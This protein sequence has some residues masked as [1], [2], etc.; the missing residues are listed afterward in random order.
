MFQFL[1]V[2]APIYS[3][4]PHDGSPFRLQMTGDSETQEREKKEVMK[5]AVR[6]LLEAFYPTSDPTK[7]PEKRV[8]SEWRAD[9]KRGFFLGIIQDGDDE[10][11]NRLH[12]LLDEEHFH[13][14]Q[15]FSSGLQLATEGHSLTFIDEMFAFYIMP[16]HKGYSD[17]VRCQTPTSVPSHPSSRRNSAE[18]LP[19]DQAGKERTHSDLKRDLKKRD[20][21]C[22]FCW[23]PKGLEAAHIIAQ[24]PVSVAHNE[25]SIL[26]RAGLE[27]KHQVQN[28]LLLCK[29]CH[30]EFD[31]L[32]Q[33]VDVS[34]DRLVVKVVNETNDPRNEYWLYD[35]RK[36]E[37][38]RSLSL[39]RW[40]DG[41]RPV[42]TNGDV[43]IYF[44]PGAPIGLLPNRT[45]LEFHKAACKI[46]QMAGGAE[47]DEE[48]C[49]DDDDDDGRIPVSYGSKNIQRWIDSSA[50]LI[51]GNSVESGTEFPL[52]P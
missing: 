23:A 10:H 11:V 6:H 22:L 8:K 37:V 2:D 35:V 17:S 9:N 15:E 14:Q 52:A 47:S 26:K 13:E 16:F 30:D 25:H 48:Y 49:P 42:E 1:V 45:A 40:T 50:T 4:I 36:I 34:D 44:A 27:N 7:G 3:T 31:K 33:Y 21:V 29:G 24:K 12:E 28:G 46:W 18:D 41:R 19:T 51:T 5:A 39:G 32:K 20:V 38:L 43:A